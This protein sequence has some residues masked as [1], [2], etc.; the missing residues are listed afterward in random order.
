MKTKKSKK[1][2]ETFEVIIPI[3]YRTTIKASNNFPNL[4]SKAQKQ[5]G[6]ELRRF[7]GDEIFLSN[8]IKKGRAHSK[9]LKEE[10]R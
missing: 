1:T 2:L 8:C 3:E 6:D 9:K 7:L 5:A 10:D 4:R